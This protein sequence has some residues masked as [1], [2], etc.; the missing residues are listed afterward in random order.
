MVSGEEEVIECKIGDVGV[1]GIRLVGT[2][3]APSGRIVQVHFRLHEG[4]PWMDAEGVLVRETLEDG[5]PA[6]GIKF[7]DLDLGTRTRLEDYVRQQ[8]PDED[9]DADENADA[10]PDADAD[11]DAS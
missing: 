4:A 11:A 10:D 1:G 6:W 8:L 3:E 9:E 7:H 2:I 5:I